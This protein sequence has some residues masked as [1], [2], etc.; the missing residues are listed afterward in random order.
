MGSGREA[1]LAEGPWVTSCVLVVDMRDT[2]VDIMAAAGF[3]W[4]SDVSTSAGDVTPTLDPAT[5]QHS[6]QIKTGD[7]RV[8]CWTP[9]G[10]VVPAC[11]LRVLVGDIGAPSLDT[12]NPHETIVLQ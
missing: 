4:A 3:I 12:G 10:D 7:F 11:D 5:T 8:Q 1:L 9:A 2:A 6:V